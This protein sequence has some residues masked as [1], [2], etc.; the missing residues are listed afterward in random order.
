MLNQKSILAAIIADETQQSP[1]EIAGWMEYPPDVA[2]GDLAFPC[3][4]LAKALRKSPQQIAQDLATIILQTKQFRS[5]EANGGY[6]NVCYHRDKL[7]QAVTDV[8]AESPLSL[9]SATRLLG[10]RAAVDYSS[11]NIAK[12]FGVGHLRSTIIGEALVHLLRADGCEVIGIN[13]L[14][15]WGT[16]FG[17]NIA[18]YLRWGD[19]EVVKRNPVKELFHLYVRFHDEATSNPGLE[20]EGRMWFRKLE[21]GDPEAQRLWRWFIDESLKVFQQTYDLLGVSFDYSLGES[22][23]NDKREPVV[24]ELRSRKLL[25]ESEGAEVVDLSAWNMPPCMIKKSDGASI[26][27]TRDLAAAL[28][29]NAPLGADTL[30]YV[31]GAEQTRKSVV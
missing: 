10:R 25:V 8:V 27:A 4:R 7:A 15:D 23:Y 6:V 24:T 31:V 18:A 20:D 29:R 14:G 21:E 9:F 17:K 28:Y 16:Q 13:H 22:F 2:L 1:A 3:F 12:P 30:I 5:A 26:Y 19:E 11:P